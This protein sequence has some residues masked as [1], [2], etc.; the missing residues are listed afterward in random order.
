[1]AIYGLLAGGTRKDHL[2]HA[3]ALLEVAPPPAD[4]P[5]IEAPEVR[6]TCSCCGGRMVI[7]EIL[8]RR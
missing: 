3:R 6:P 7:I 8:Q 4:D 2:Q 1:M 5:P